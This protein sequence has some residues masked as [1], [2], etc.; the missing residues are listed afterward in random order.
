VPVRDVATAISRGD[1]AASAGRLGLAIDEY[2]LGAD[3]DA[4]EPT[5][6]M[7]IAD[8]QLWELLGQGMNA[9]LDEPRRQVWLDTMSQAIRRNPQA[10]MLA[11]WRA[12]QQLTYY[13]RFG[14]KRELA[15]A[16]AEL[17]R[18]LS[19]SPGDIRAVAQLAAV[20]QSLGEVEQAEQLWQRADSLVR[21][22]EHVERRLENVRVIQV[23]V[24]GMEVASAGVVRKTAA[25]TRQAGLLR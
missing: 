25:E 15:G 20:L 7:R 8:A 9:E 13:Q 18:V 19:L 11:V 21:R 3:A 5:P 6:W 16:Q 2:R 24:L 23:A 17:E 12:E 1:A 14:D 10:P 22:G 4:W